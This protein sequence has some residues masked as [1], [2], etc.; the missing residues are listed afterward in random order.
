[1]VRHIM[2]FGSFWDGLKL[3]KLNRDRLSVAEDLEPYTYYRYPPQSMCQ[4]VYLRLMVI[5]LM[6]GAMLS[7][8][9]L[10]SNMINTFTCLPR[11]TIAARDRKVPIQMIVGRSKS[12]R[13][14]TW[15]GMVL[16]M[17]KGGGSVLLAGDK[18]WYGVGHNG[19]STFDGGDHI[20]FHGYD[21]A[22]RGI[23][24]YQN[25]WVDELK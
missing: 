16:D 13:G 8:P 17:N 12:L 11:S 5:Q 2:V 21:A 7:K 25:Y 15:M 1:M 9:L 23:S 22:D 14:L 24:K 19:V 18:N 4:K 6:P 3:V 20:I 10:F